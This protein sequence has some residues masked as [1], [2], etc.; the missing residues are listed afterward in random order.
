MRSFE[1]GDT[2]SKRQ[3]DHNSIIR[4]EVLIDGNQRERAAAALELG[5]KEPIQPLFEVQAPA[6]LQLQMLKRGL[7]SRRSVSAALTY[8]SV[9]AAFRAISV[10]RNTLFSAAHVEV[11]QRSHATF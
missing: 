5:L 10:P 8:I 11:S 7:V 2:I 3:G 4:R 9:I 1:T 6:V